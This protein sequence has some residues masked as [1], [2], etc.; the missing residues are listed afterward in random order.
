MK[1]C[2]LAYSRGYLCG[3][4]GNLSIRLADDHILSTAS[5]TCKGLLTEDDLVLTDLEGLRTDKGKDSR[6]SKPS[7]ELKMHLLAYRLRPDI[8]AVMHAHPTV[9]VGLTVAGRKLSTAILPEVLCNL[10]TIPVASYATPSTDEV[11]ESL[12]PYLAESD[13]IVLDHHGAITLGANLHEAYFKMEMLEHHSQTLMIAELLG[14]AVPL[15][16]EQVAKLMAVRSVYGL[17]RPVRI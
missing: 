16:T 9:T 3:T 13:A 8:A 7:T 5:N 11:P 12:R 4:E 15:N 6:A 1:V 14:G 10:G 17:T 2:H